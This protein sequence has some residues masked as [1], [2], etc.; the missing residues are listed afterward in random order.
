VLGH[1]LWRRA[2]GSDPRVIGRVIRL[3]GEPYTVVGVLPATFRSAVLADL[4][5]PLR[6]ATTGEGEGINYEVVARLR[7]G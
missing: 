5:T 3:K 2:F 1:G 6:L 7:P 4:W